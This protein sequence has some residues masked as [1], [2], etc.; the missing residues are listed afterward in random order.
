M[1]RP[2]RRGRCHPSGDGDL[3]AGT[4]SL[5]GGA[6]APV[7]RVRHADARAR[8]RGELVRSARAAI[9]SPKRPTATP[10]APHVPGRR[11]R[12]RLARFPAI[13]SGATRPREAPAR[14]RALRRRERSRLEHL[15]GS[16]SR[17]VVRPRP[18]SLRAST[19][20]ASRRM[21]RWCETVGCESANASVR[22]QTQHS[23]PD[24]R[25]LTIDT[26]V[27]SASALKTP[28]SCSASRA[29]ITGAGR[30]PQQSGWRVGSVFIDE[31]QCS[32]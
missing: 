12:R 23:S 8:R 21:R 32:I 11:T 3:P 30:A 25:R 27:G 17:P 5:E 10:V 18:A 31:R 22:S 6:P 26:R 13:T 7:G 24:A 1:H 16:R 2:R 29:S 15:A 20:P 28:A 9:G 14:S 19:R 4:Q